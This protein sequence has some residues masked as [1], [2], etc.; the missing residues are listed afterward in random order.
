MLMAREIDVFLLAFPALLSIINPVG[1]AF[2]FLTVTR[3]ASHAERET[4]ARAIAIYGFVLLNASLYVGAYLLEFFGVSLP[5]LRVGGGMVVAVTAWKL[6]QADEP[7]ESVEAEARANCRPG[8]LRKLAFYPLTMPITTGPGTISVAIA[9]GTARSGGVQGFV[10][11][12]IGASLATVANCLL[13]YVCYRYADRVAARF[14][15]TGTQIVMRLS[16]F[17]L[18][19][20]GLQVLWNGLSELLGMLPRH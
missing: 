13:I 10:E 17:L 12:A 6:L 19:C 14:G 5:V 11:F 9:L 1:G 2:T 7:E 15:V 18:L 20:I 4:T 3:R 16:A 8:E